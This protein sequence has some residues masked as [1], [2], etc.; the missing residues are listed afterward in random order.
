MRVPLRW[1]EEFV[2][3]DVP[4]ERLAELLD[5]SGT[6]VE[7]IAK[8]TG[9]T[10]GV[11]VAEVLH[12]E[13][14]PNA[15]NLSLVEVRTEASQQSAD[16]VVC[17][18]RNFGV[19]DRVPF[20][21]V[22][23]R[24]P[25]MEI[26]ERKIR[27]EISR[28]M[29]CSAAELGVSSDHSGILVL[30]ADAELGDDVVP[31]LG[32]DDTVFELE[33]T[34]NRP[35]CMSIL[36]IA[37]EVS[38]LLGNELKVPD[39]EL[40]G[41][42][43]VTSPVSVDVQDRDGCPRYLARYVENVSVAPSPSWL[44]ARLLR[45]GVR[46][47]SNVVDVTNYVLFEL[48][49][50]LHAFDARNVHEAGI[51]VRRARRGERMHTLDGQ[52]RTLHEEDLLIADRRR[53]LA[54]AGVMGG[55]DSEVSSETHAVILESA[56]F[57]PV[58]VAMTSRRH[59]LRTEA[60]ARFERG[61]D[62]EMV[63][64]AAARAAG[65]MEQLAGGVAS[66]TETDV[67]PQPVQ[68]KQLRL[69]PARAG[70][71]LGADLS[72]SQQIRYLSALGLR[73]EEAGSLLEVEVPTFRPD[74]TREVDLVE[75]VGRLAGFGRLPD[76]LPPGRSGRLERGQL[77][78]R[79][80]RRLLVDHG[81]HE[82]WTSSFMSAAD[83]DRLGLGPEHPA[84]RSIRLAN[85]MTEDESLLRTTLLPGLLTAAAVNERHGAR[86]VAL[87]EMARIYE[88]VDDPLPREPSILGGILTGTRRPPS[89]DST[90]EAWDLFDAKGLV[91]AV[92]DRLR[93][94]APTFAAAG[95]MP[96]HPTRAA[97]MSFRGDPVGAIGEIHPDV[98]E[99]W[100]LKG[101][102]IAFELA[103][104]PLYAALPD[105]AKV[106]ELPRYPSNLVDIAVVVDQEVPSHDVWASIQEAGRPELAAVRL[107][108]VYEGDQVPTGKKS[109]AFALELRSPER[110]LTDP[111]ASEVI[112]RVM[113][114]LG[115]RFAAELR[116]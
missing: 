29:L 94:E 77:A 66:A 83:I 39:L 13:P 85:P 49:Q 28:G 97:T 69:R 3:V 19:G 9:V 78:D 74:L 108:D 67:Y 75:E 51:V 100:D 55:A 65:L 35:D 89:W 43:G 109:L 38:A 32:L 20:A 82:A 111:E 112:E 80:I 54:I 34:P 73:V 45:V 50:P 84:A 95:G 62:P 47:I 64:A 116:S 26:T 11:V 56:H 59:G 4:P 63:G 8:P 44:A 57:D 48:G 27:G 81:L 106:E 37:R 88:P 17:G 14:H 86:R 53:P 22:G 21:Q 42:D 61:S 115:E 6:K 7:S 60:S 103:L 79:E 114:S 105:R 110:T 36:G 98:L 16:R 104:V 93:L 76:T 52:E 90:D 5:L 101:S 92:F 46:P 72:S 96:F 113:S 23:A 10:E 31:L 30:P 41:S 87:F 71:L 91:E 70:V 25:E 24:L 12:I 102:A 33:I 15:D 18:A 107:F 2:P 68:R 58:S 40:G 1:L 99:R